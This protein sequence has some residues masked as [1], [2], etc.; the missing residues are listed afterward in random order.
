[1]IV[2]PAGMGFVTAFD[3]GRIVDMHRADLFVATVDLAGG[4]ER[5]LP[6]LRAWG[7]A[8]R[9]AELRDLLPN[10]ESPS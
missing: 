1:M 2:R 9:I 6:L 8:Q 5:D 3:I 7:A 10:K 4:D